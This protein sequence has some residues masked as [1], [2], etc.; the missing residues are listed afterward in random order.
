MAVSLLAGC[1]AY[2][3]AD[4]AHP[5][6]ETAAAALIDC[7]EH[8]PVFMGTTGGGTMGLAGIAAYGAAGGEERTQ[9]CMA[10]KGFAAQKVM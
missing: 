4:P 3:P 7:N 5:P 10:R 1:T 9:S 8:D 2:H 6:A